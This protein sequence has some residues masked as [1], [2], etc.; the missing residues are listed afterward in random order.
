MPHLERAT[1][2]ALPTSSPPPTVP[3]AG[4]NTY[5]LTDPS[6]AQR[7]NSV[8]GVPGYV[9]AMAE[10]LVQ[11]LPTPRRAD[12]HRME[13]E[14]R[15]MSLPPLASEEEDTAEASSAV[16]DDENS[17]SVEGDVSDAEDAQDAAEAE[18]YTP[19]LK[20]GKENIDPQA[21]RFLYRASGPLRLLLNCNILSVDE[22]PNCTLGRPIEDINIAIQEEG[23]SNARLSTLAQP[24]ASTYKARLQN[25]HAA[26]QAAEPLVPIRKP[27]DTEKFNR[28]WLL[29][30]C[31]LARACLAA[32]PAMLVNV[33]PVGN[34]ENALLADY[35]GD[36]ALYDSAIVSASGPVWSR[37]RTLRE[38]V[39]QSEP[40]DNSEIPKSMGVIGGHREGRNRGGSRASR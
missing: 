32:T 3:L 19:T 25:R 31:L 24:F 35:V 30:Y 6:L 11:P 27:T 23:S 5:N 13:D 37:P 1:S 28:A 4:N 39:E 22:A 29:M 21:G 16:L 18:N 8:T 26:P 36:R 38:L 2:V 34:H 14:V 9:H 20:S 17:D 33:E 7:T 15:N 40:D 12:L 10:P